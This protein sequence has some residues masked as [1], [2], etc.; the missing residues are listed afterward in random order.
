MENLTKSEKN[1]IYLKEYYKNN[2][3]KLLS[4]GKTKCQ[5]NNCGRIVIRNNILTH[6]KKN[7]CINHKEKNF[8]EL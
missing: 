8:T 4:Y 7:I 3:E 2:K 1:K 5:C 6:Q